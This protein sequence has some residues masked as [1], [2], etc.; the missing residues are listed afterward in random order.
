VLNDIS[1]TDE[2]FYCRLHVLVAAP[3]FNGKDKFSLL[4]Q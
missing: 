4:T 1:A 3:L 2:L